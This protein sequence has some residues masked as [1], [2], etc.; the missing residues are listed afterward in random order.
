M[1]H[2]T[3]VREAAE[4]VKTE[5]VLHRAEASIQMDVLSVRF[6]EDLEL[7]ADTI[8]AASPPAA[9]TTRR[10]CD[11]HAEHLAADLCPACLFE[12]LRDAK[13][14]IRDQAPAAETGRDE[15]I[16]ELEK[17]RDRWSR[18]ELNMRVLHGGLPGTGYDK[19]ADGYGTCA[20]E[21][22]ELLARVSRQ[23][24]GEGPK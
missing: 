24:V 22:Q 17:L 3:P 19:L 7:L 18:A 6:T 5:C 13:A 10:N 4:R 8:L 2:E 1:S 20:D 23:P 16:E 15:L 9:E 11:Q 14:K 12:Q 21:L